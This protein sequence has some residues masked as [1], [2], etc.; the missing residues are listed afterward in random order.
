MEMTERSKGSLSSGKQEAW[1]LMM[2]RFPTGEELLFDLS[3]KSS[4]SGEAIK[5]NNSKSCCFYG[6]RTEVQI[7][8]LLLNYVNYPGLYQNITCRDLG[9]L[10]IR[11]GIMLVH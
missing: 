9:Y 6:K 5:I 3:L 10:D 11:Q 7:H 4:S 2:G 8:C 1:E